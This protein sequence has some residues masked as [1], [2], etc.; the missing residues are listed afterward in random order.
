[1]GPDNTRY[2][3]AQF[4]LILLLTG[5]RGSVE[6]APLAPRGHLAGGRCPAASPS[7]ETRSLKSEQLGNREDMPHTHATHEL[8]CAWDYKTRVLKFHSLGIHE[9]PR[10]KHVSVC[11]YL[12][13]FRMTRCVM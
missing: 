7:R 1:M 4:D 13:M 6:S 3:F 12:F 8:S 10:V 11:L 2:P 9:H 5:D